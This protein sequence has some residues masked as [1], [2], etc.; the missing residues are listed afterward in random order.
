MALEALKAPAHIWSDILEAEVWV[1]ANQAQTKDVQAEGTTI[2]L[3]AEIRVLHQLKAR[4][5]E[6]FPEKLQ[7]I[8]QSKAVFGAFVVEAAV[9]ENTKEKEPGV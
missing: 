4:W 5:P 3:P 8:H 7:A 9:P 2:Y 1:C 6:S